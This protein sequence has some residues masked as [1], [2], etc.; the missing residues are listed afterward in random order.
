MFNKKE[1][2]SCGEEINKRYMYCPYCGN[3]SGENFEKK[4]YGML[5]E[6]DFIDEF[7]EFQEGLLGTPTGKVLGK[8]FEN[9][10]KILE[11]EMQKEMKRKDR[12]KSGMPRSNFQ[13]FINGKKVTNFETGHTL[14]QKVKKKKMEIRSSDLPQNYLRDFSVLPK[15]EPKTNVRRFSDKVIYEINVPGVKSVKDI[16]IIKL[17]NNIEIKAVSKNKA[18]SKLIP[19]NFPITDYNLS[20]GKLVLELDSR[21][22]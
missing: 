8:M 2:K 9:A 19:V 15:N 3:L 1:C 5:G 12:E 17:E 7:E 11:K 22:N 18:Y 10:I 13:L 6:E 20:N 16:S 21:E 4:D 14:K